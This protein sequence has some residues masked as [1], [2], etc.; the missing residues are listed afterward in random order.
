MTMAP[1]NGG[2]L[3]CGV[4]TIPAG[5]GPASGVLRA[6]GRPG[7]ASVRFA[8]AGLA[9][10]G[11]ETMLHHL[12]PALLQRQLCRI[13]MQTGPLSQVAGPRIAPKAAFNLRLLAEAVY[14]SC[15]AGRFSHDICY[16]VA[17]LVQLLR[18]YPP[19]GG[20]K[21]SSGLAQGAID[22]W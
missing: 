11:V 12:V 22:H 13:Q 21:R 16:T 14:G 6:Y 17:L 15:N 1:F 2:G 5:C 3:R 8:H 4:E 18:V 7:V 20:W 19:C 9:L 10:C